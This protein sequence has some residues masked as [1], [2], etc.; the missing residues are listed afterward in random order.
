MEAVLT[1]NLTMRWGYTLLSSEYDEYNKVSRSINDAVR[2]GRCEIITQDGVL[3]CLVDLSG[4]EVEDIP[5][6]QL[7]AGLSW[8]SGL[9]NGAEFM[10]DLDVQYQGSR[11]EAEWNQVEFESYMLA[12][13]RVGLSRDSW[14]VMAYVENL[15]DDDTLKSGIS[16]PDFGALGFLPPVPSL[17]IFGPTL[18]F[19]NA[20]TLYYPDPREFGVR[21]S[22]TF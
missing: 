11:W 19:P 16:A 2:G 4:N 15:F 5:R 8:R 3:T 21:A 6:H 9:A 14:T 13:V 7:F 22:Y 1:D 12:D 18:L 10:I 20:T 17:G